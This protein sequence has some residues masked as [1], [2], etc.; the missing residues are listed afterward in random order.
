MSLTQQLIDA[1]EAN[2]NGKVPKL[3]ERMDVEAI[4]GT[5]SVGESPLHYA[6]VNNKN[7]AVAL[8]LARPEININARSCSGETPLHHAFYNKNT[9]TAE[10]LLARPGINI[11]ATNN[12]GDTPLHMACANK[13]QAVALLLARPD[14]NINATDENGETPLHAACMNN[15]SQAVALLLARPDININARTTSGETPIMWSA[16]YCS[17]ETLKMMLEDSRVDIKAR[18]D[19][20]KVLEEMV[21]DD[22]GNTTDK[23]NCLAMIRGKRSRRENNHEVH[24]K[25]SHK[26]INGQSGQDLEK[27]RATVKAAQE[28]LE[29]PVCTEFM[30]PPTRIW[31]CSSSHIM[32]ESCKDKIE[33]RLCPTCRTERV[34]MRALFAEKFARSIFNQ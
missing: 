1:I 23:K 28:T 27:L 7:Q 12:Y 31:M 16:R 22:E 2:N 6:C 33:G 26:D 20:G 8:L 15:N 18:R 11:N 17:S 10:L 25:E 34:T 24:E 30:K 5:N 4:N 9:Q 3:L 32:C 29:C 21:G 14:I 19:D 13:N